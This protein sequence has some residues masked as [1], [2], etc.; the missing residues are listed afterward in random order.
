MLATLFLAATI[1]VT[2]VCSRYASFELPPAALREYTECSDEP[3]CL[4]D[5]AEE[6]ANGE[7]VGRDYDVASYALC[8]V[9]ER[10]AQAEVEGMLEH[11]QAMRDGDT[12]EDLEFCDHVTSGVGQARCAS[13]RSS[14]V[15]PAL[16]ERLDQ[17]AAASTEKPLLTALRAAAARYVVAETDRVGEGSRLGTGY[18]AIVMEEEMDETQ[19]FVEAL[20]AR[21][22][23]R[24]PA[25]TASAL[26]SADRTLNESYRR[27]LASSAAFDDDRVSQWQYV[28]R[29]S[30]RAWM[31]Y[32][33]AFAAW[34]AAHWKD[35]ASAQ[36]LRREIL[37]ELTARRAKEFADE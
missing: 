22:K 20:E 18:A 16:E 6:Y 35:A 7:G 4:V 12:T 2:H 11:V 14:E 32:R 37:A 5:L 25:A 9:S 28:F 29:N 15:L 13:I 10:V 21:T 27:A 3:Y 36:V 8:H 1:N 26:A 30:Q 31:A 17:L 19:A 33:D 24:A 34:Y 23:E